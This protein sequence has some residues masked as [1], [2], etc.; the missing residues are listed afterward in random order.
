MTYSDTYSEDYISGGLRKRDVNGRTYTAFYWINESPYAN[1]NGTPKNFINV[2]LP[3]NCYISIRK[4][5][6]QSNWVTTHQEIF[7]KGSEAWY[8]NSGS[9]ENKTYKTIIKHIIT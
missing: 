4:V 7:D 6:A 2:P 9:D 1:P 3:D 8:L 5:Y